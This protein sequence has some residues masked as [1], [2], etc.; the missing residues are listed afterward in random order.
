MR[1]RTSLLEAADT[2]NLG[3]SIAIPHRKPTP[4]QMKKLLE[5]RKAKK[6]EISQLELSDRSL[7]SIR[8]RSRTMHAR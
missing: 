5:Q 7:L 3:R 4:E 8:E 2:T 6:A 1:M